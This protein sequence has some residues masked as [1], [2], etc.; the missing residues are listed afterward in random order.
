MSRLMIVALALLVAACGRDSEEAEAPGVVVTATP[1]AEVTDASVVDAALAADLL[2]RIDAETATM[3]LSLEPMPAALM[4]RIWSSLAGMDELMDQDDE[5]V[6]EAIDNPLMRALW[7]E[8]AQLDSP[9]AYAERGLDPNGMSALHLMSIF[10]A[11]HWQLSDAEA[12][13]AM[14]ARIETEAETALP[15]QNVDGHEV[16]WID[17][18]R[19]GLALHHDEN[20]VT[21]ALV[22]NREDLLRRVANLDR[23]PDPMQRATV[24]AFARQRGLQQDNFGFIDFQRLLALSLDGDDE[25][26]TQLRS[27]TP[28]GR[29]AADPACRSELGQLTEIFPRKSF[30]TA[31][32]T[33][34]SLSMKFTL[35][36]EPTFGARMAALADSPMALDGHQGGVIS[37]GIALNLIA[38][39]DFARELVGGWVENPPQCFLLEEV[40]ENAASWQLALNRPIPP[41]VTNIHGARLNLS[42]L[43]MGSADVPDLAAT[44][45]VFMRNPQMLIGMAQMFS[46]ELAGL[47]LR[48]GGDPQPVPSELIPQLQGT[49]AWIGLS[50]TGLGLA[51]GANQDAALPAAL[52]AGSA[53]SAILSFSLDFTAYSELMAMGLA[54]LPGQTAEFDADEA[55]EAMRLFAAVYRRMASSLHLSE[56]GIETRVTVDLAD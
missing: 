46:P 11:F 23:A 8:F 34:T 40:G 48:P 28:L 29:A 52:T 41:V 47:D 13:S 38:A 33:D 17:M 9:E 35:E 10:P 15:R 44:V 42:E 5:E 25:L 54:N 37:I 26:L 21:A 31:A 55:A 50:D 20:F 1:G 45:A 36:S 24:D 6:A 39:R 7:M 56:A 30:G 4:D 53:D 14:L 12:F 2:A 32:I 18:D 16:I 19:I 3:W 27:D 51:V 49:P 22:S 43:T